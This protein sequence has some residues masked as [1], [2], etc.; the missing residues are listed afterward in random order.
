MR[1][2]FGKFELDDSSRKLSRAGQTVKLTGQ[3]LDLLTLLVKRPGQ[4]IARDEIK[5]QLWPDSKLELEHSLDVLI[6]RLRSILGDSGACPRYIET[7][8]R[9]GYRFLGPVRC[10]PDRMTKTAKPIVMRRLARYAAIALLAAAATLLIV[11]SRYD[12]FVP[13]RRAP[14]PATQTR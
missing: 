3:A 11:H 6:N 2:I 10:E 13:S 5:R 14:T 7:V 4:L 9:R 1:R 8:P 12:R